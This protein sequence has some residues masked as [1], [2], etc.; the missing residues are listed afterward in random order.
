MSALG[1]TC[2]VQD[3]NTCDTL[4]RSDTAKATCQIVV[5][6]RIWK[7]PSLVNAETA[8]RTMG[9]RIWCQVCALLSSVINC[10]EC[11]CDVRVSNG[12]ILCEPCKLNALGLLDPSE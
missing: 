9:S 12:S 4:N 11:D 6:G 5:P 7:S 3:L 10:L 1:V 8:R 2:D